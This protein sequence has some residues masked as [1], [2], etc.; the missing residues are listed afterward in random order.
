MKTST[1]I[2]ETLKR[3]CKGEDGALTRLCGATSWVSEADIREEI[4]G[5]RESKSNNIKQMP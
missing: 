1:Q 2:E 4:F 3:S 5:Q